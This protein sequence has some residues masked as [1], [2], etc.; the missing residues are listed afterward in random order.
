M[1]D[2]NPRFVEAMSRAD[3]RPVWLVRVSINR[4]ETISFVSRGTSGMDYPASVDSVSTVS[5][6]IDPFS[7]EF[8]TNMVDVTFVDDGTIRDLAS[9]RWVKGKRIDILLGAVGLTEGD[10]ESRFSG[11]IDDPQ[12]DEGSLVLH[13]TDLSS[14]L[15]DTSVQGFWINVHPI[16]V[17]ASIEPTLASATGI[18]FEA[19]TFRPDYDDRT[20][21]WKVSRHA[22]FDGDLT[23]SPMPTIRVPVGSMQLVNE[24]L[25]LTG[26]SL[27]VNRFGNMEYVPFH[28]DAPPIRTLGRDDIGDMRQLAT[29]AHLTNHHTITFLKDGTKLPNGHAVYKHGSNDPQAQTDIAYPGTIRRIVATSEETDWLNAETRLASSISSGAGAGSTFDVVSPVLFGLPTSFV[30]PAHRVIFLVDDELIECDLATAL[31]GA[32]GELV[33]PDGMIAYLWR[34]RISQRALFGTEQLSH[35]P[36]SGGGGYVV[37]YTIAV[38]V[39]DRKVSRFSHGIPIVEI[40]T[41]MAQLDLDLGDAIALEDDVALWTGFDGVD[42]SLIWEIVGKE[43]LPSDDSPRITFTLAVLRR[44]IQLPQVIS[45]SGGET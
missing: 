21:H 39:T 32:D 4:A 12:P 10:F 1:E 28:A 20:K 9:T 40:T 22:R 26:G 37:D 23:P 44:E 42:T 24:I 11:V 31:P 45:G 18:H 14:S 34:Y 17:I 43:E 3:C 5:A 13:C 25:A 6:K 27:V 19:H 8:S 29:A 15:R 16:E 2:L 41:S 7:R 33:T 36:D 30:D 35:T 38:S